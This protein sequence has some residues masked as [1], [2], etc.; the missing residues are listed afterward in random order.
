M[1]LTGFVETVRDA[2]PSLVPGN[3]KV[4]YVTKPLFNLG[5]M[6]KHSADVSLVT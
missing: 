5:Y 4:T 1:G 6:I 2:I 3:V